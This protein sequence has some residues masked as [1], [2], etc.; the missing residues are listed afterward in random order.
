MITAISWVGDRAYIRCSDCQKMVQ[1]NK[2]VFGGLHVCV[3]ACQKAQ[4]ETGRPDFHWSAK[5]RRRG[6]F[7]ARRTEQWCGVCGEVTS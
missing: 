5:T 4:R 7:W 2:P 3:S 1:L 6:P